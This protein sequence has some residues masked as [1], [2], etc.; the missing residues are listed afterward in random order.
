[1]G[2]KRAPTH[3]GFDIIE[4]ALANIRLAYAHGD[5]ANAAGYAHELAKYAV[6]LA[7]EIRYEHGVKAGRAREKAEAD[8][9]RHQKGKK[10]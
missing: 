9:R 4:G 10:A 8:K 3:V 5:V 1:M 7:D 2:K 6:N